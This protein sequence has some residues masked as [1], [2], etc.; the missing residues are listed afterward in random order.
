M[1]W[2]F[3]LLPSLGI[4]SVPVSY[5]LL[6]GLRWSAIPQIQP[7]RELIYTV[8][9]SSLGCGIAGLTAA[10]DRRI[11][12]ALLWLTVV[13][14]VPLQPHMLD[15]LGIATITHLAELIFSIAL[16]ATLVGL[17]LQFGGT[18]L[19]PV[20]LVVPLLAMLAGTAT[21]WLQHMPKVNNTSIDEI[22]IWA[23][24]NTWGSSMFLFPD[25]GRALYPGRF[26]AESRRALW[27][28]WK[29]GSLSN[30]FES[31]ADDWYERWQGTMDQPFSP[32]HLQ[33]ML[34][35]PVDYLVLKRTDRLPGVKPVFANHD[36]VVYD[37]RELR[38]IL[39]RSRPPD[40]RSV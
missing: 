17:V 36:F 21:R 9:T 25:A 24:N 35:L 37:A 31:F 22:A 1:R 26:R 13:F 6:E 7:A 8:I 15:L 23:Q 12:E 3:L 39:A 28:D 40:K 30:Y 20:V 2:L 10:L 18:K 38:Q 33:S 34:S 16:A 27:V 11:P 14:A 19:R 32:A 4:V 29:S 5:G